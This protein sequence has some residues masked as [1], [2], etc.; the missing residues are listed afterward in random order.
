[1]S[2]YGTARAQIHRVLQHTWLVLVPTTLCFVGAALW[3]TATKDRFSA[4][5]ILIVRT[6]KPADRLLQ[7]AVAA[8]AKDVMRTVQQRMLP[9]DHLAEVTK[10]QELYPELWRLENGKVDDRGMQEAVRKMR[11]NLMVRVDGRSGTV[12]VAYTTSAGPH[13]SETCRD[14]VNQLVK[15]FTSRHSRSVTTEG[16]G[17]KHFLETS[18]AQSRKD[19][20]LAEGTLHA[21]RTKHAGQLPE[22]VPQQRDNIQIAERRIE[23]AKA[24][25]ERNRLSIDNLQIE[26]FQARESLR[27]HQEEFHADDEIRGLRGVVRTLRHNL[28]AAGTTHTEDSDVITGLK[29][30]IARG[31]KRI[32]ELIAAKKAEDTTKNHTTLMFEALIKMH[33]RNITTLTEQNKLSQESILVA[34]KA[35]ETA[36]ENVRISNDIKNEY[37]ALVREVETAKTRRNV[38]EGK[39][40]AA[41]IQVRF[42]E[43]DGD[44]DA[45]TP[46]EIYERARVNS[47]PVGPKRL[48]M[49]LMGLA[50][51]LAA[52]VGLV[53]LKTKMDRSV[54]TSD[55]IRL[56]LPGAVVITMPEVVSVTDRAYRWTGR[57]VLITCLLAAIAVGVAGLGIRMEWWGDPATLDAWL[58]SIDL[59]LPR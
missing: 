33:E 22:D 43:R 35:I 8:S 41:D 42:G 39:L 26:L 10:D 17:I 2:L 37:Q 25:Q 59:P 29:D 50:F 28:L 15:L 6:A 18:E 34:H 49:S 54:R 24:A 38:L 31:E 21:F 27:L 19:L 46:V 57:I 16:A 30:Q 7:S 44:M 45:A 20:Q 51:G 23:N 40:Q 3:A 13:P 53:I 4:R 1:M 14:V 12:H 32:A 58:D 47:L 9:Y 48:E 5:S 56:L 11:K 55:D 52:G 36:Q